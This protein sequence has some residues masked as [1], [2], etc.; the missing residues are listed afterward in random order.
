MK[1]IEQKNESV[2]LIAERYK[3]YYEDPAKATE[4]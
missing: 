1:S 3:T 4:I 2:A